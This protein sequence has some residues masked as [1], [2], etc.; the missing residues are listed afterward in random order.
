[1]VRH[2]RSHNASCSK[3]KIKNQLFEPTSTT[4]FSVIDSYGNVASIT[5][6][7]EN[8]FG[9]RL[10]TSGF[11]LNNQLS[12]FNFKIEGDFPKDESINKI[13]QSW[14]KILDN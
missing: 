4:H 1:M 5:S 3:I 11:L 13:V 6:S 2:P 12:D 10:M 7:I 9:S 14:N 8:T